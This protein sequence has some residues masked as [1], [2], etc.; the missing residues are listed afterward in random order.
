MQE[1]ENNLEREFELERMILFSDAVFAIAI[2]LLI[3]EVKFPELHANLS[4]AEI[5]S[6]FQP[7]IVRFFAFAI[8]FFFIGTMWAKHLEIFK[9]LRTYNST[10]IT[11]N[12][13]FIFFIVC[14]PFTVSGFSENSPE[15]FSLPLFFYVGNIT[16][17]SITKAM[18]CY[19]LFR[20]D[21]P[22]TI[23]GF[24]PEKKYLLI[25]SILSAMIFVITVTLM[26]IIYKIFPDNPRYVLNS[27]YVLLIL[28]IFL[29]RYLKK[30]KPAKP[31]FGKIVLQHL[32]SL[33]AIKGKK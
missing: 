3:L 30:L 21:S 9:Y 32:L 1:L 13:L 33:K 22:C 25:E 28:V 17:V 18:L 31:S 27:I 24:L 15:R 20:K 19:Y 14:F 26:F 7:V 4:N 2:T 12:L 8:S 29:R 11:I 16:C 5:K 10:L 6:L 23:P